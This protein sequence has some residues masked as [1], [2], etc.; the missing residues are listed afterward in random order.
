MS[1]RQVSVGADQLQPESLSGGGAGSHIRRRYRQ[2]LPVQEARCAVP[3]QHHN[4]IVMIHLAFRLRCRDEEATKRGLKEPNRQRPSKRAQDEWL[5][6]SH[7]VSPYRGCEPSGAVGAKQGVSF[8]TYTG[9]P[10]Q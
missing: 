3:V 7:G 5:V 9:A 2:S 4:E 10:A 6:W 8:R 1:S